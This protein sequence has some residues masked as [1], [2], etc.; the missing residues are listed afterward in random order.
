MFFSCLPCFHYPVCASSFPF[1]LP[2][3]PPNGCYPSPPFL[4]LRE[5][6]VLRTSY[7][8]MNFQPLDT[9]PVCAVC[10]VPVT[11]NFV[12]YV[13]KRPYT[14]RDMIL[15][16]WT[17]ALSTFPPP[18]FLFASDVHLNP[19]LSDYFSHES[20]ENL[21]FFC[22]RVLFAPPFPCAGLFILGTRQVF[23]YQP[24]SCHIPF[25]VITALMPTFS[26]MNTFSIPLLS[27]LL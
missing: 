13:P 11:K 6:S 16:S 10:P 21:P 14:L 27:R 2:L 12:L 26:N 22:S 19:F 5:Y 4:Q 17:S 18:V 20:V 8:K 23:M 3:V 9:A 25:C 15:I 7:F 24:H 1:F